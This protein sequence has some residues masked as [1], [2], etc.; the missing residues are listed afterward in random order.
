V[1]D[2]E[3]ERARAK[4]RDFAPLHL[5]L[6][7]YRPVVRGGFE[8][9]LESDGSERMLDA[10]VPQGSPERPA[11][12]ARAHL[13]AGADH[14]VLQPAGTDGLPGAEW[15]ALAAALIA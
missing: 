7:N 9:D 4:A 15:T 10:V 8:E 13:E 3:P 5:S 11:A 2:E 12:A 14:V 6:A 1:L